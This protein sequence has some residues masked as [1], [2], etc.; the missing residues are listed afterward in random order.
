[1]T[2]LTIR[3]EKPEAKLA[4]YQGN[5]KLAEKKWQAH[6]TLA[7]TINAELDKMLNMLS[8][9]LNDIE[10]IIC[11]Q[12]PGSFTG[13]RIG[14]SVGNTLSYAQKIPIVATR[15]DDWI[16][17]GTKLLEAGKNQNI[18]QPYYDRP[19]AVTLPKN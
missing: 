18:I 17:A 7:E 1:M 15:E 10:G 2:I 3:T 6:G 11:Y 13:L 5:K 9:S 16:K 12:G 14:M 19:A 4:I 8:I